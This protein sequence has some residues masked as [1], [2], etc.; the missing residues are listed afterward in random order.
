MFFFSSRRRHTRCA[1][2]TG[3]QTCALPIC[4]D[5]DSAELLEPRQIMKNM[6]KIVKQRIGRNGLKVQYFNE[7]M[8]LAF[9]RERFVQE[10]KGAFHFVLFDPFAY[11]EGNDILP[12]VQL[13]ENGWFLPYSSRSQVEQIGSAHV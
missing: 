3:V 1:L 6:A 7:D 9:A 2:V 8:N 12:A 13:R 11:R 10:P 5:C 4:D